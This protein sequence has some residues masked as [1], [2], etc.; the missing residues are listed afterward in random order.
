MNFEAW[1][2]CFYLKNRERGV[3]RWQ[4]PCPYGPVSGQSSFK[5]KHLGPDL[6]RWMLKKKLAAF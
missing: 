4:E 2:F 3:S 5:K 6:L 1:T